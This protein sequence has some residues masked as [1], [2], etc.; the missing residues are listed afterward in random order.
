MCLLAPNGPI[1]NTKFTAKRAQ[2][3]TSIMTM[4]LHNPPTPDIPRVVQMFLVCMMSQITIMRVR[5]M[6]SKSKI[7]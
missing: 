6:L 2:Y 4:V 1:N 3:S 7:E 5:R